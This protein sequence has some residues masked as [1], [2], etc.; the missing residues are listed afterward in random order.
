MLPSPEKLCK[1]S[2][3]PLPLVHYVINEVCVY[4]TDFFHR[5]ACPRSEAGVFFSA[6]WSA[7]WSEAGVCF[8]AW[9]LPNGGGEARKEAGIQE[10]PS[11]N[12]L[13]PDDLQ[14]QKGFT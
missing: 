3:L 4:S 8:G 1:P 2:P 5:A 9:P 12:L 10:R 7:W 14:H 6:W 11:K 13:H